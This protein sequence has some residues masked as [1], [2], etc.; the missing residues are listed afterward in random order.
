MSSISRA[1]TLDVPYDIPYTDGAGSHGIPSDPSDLA[2][3]HSK[4][5]GRT[6]D[7]CVFAIILSPYQLT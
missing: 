3:G 2:G 4:V 6:E 5:P 1:E 7:R